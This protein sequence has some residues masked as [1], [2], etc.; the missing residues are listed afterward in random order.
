M[1]AASH[2]PLKFAGP[3]WFS[4]VMGL[5]GLSLAWYRAQPLMGDHAGVLAAVLGAAAA[6][7]FAVL[8]V[9]A[10]R[11]WQRYP[12]AW[13]DD[14]QHPVRHAFVAALPA[15]MI[16]LATVGTAVL[17]VQSAFTP[18]LNA[19]WIA[20]AA[21]QWAV[22]V[23]VL[24][25]WWRPG[26]AAGAVANPGPGA[27]GFQWASITPVMF[28]P[29]VGNVLVPLAGVPLGHADWSAA[30]F[31]VGVLF[32]PVLLVLIVVRI[33][34]Q[35]FWP[36]RLLPSAFIFLAPPAVV[37]TSLL[38]MGAPAALAWG[39]WG[40]ALFSLL[41]VGT[42]LPRIKRLEFGLPH[43]AMSFPLA[44]TA[45]LSLRLATPGSGMALFALALL[46]LASVV[47]FALLAGT[48]RGLRQGTLLAPEPVATLQVVGSA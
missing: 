47:V 31:G 24:A 10:V 44:S 11:R 8:A 1:T 22:T 48:V 6:L 16:L 25:C 4:I 26:K 33:A 19:L 15:S 12:Q 23:W 38:Q 3:A 9:A 35:G 39:C 36:E 29:V 32:W 30:Q 17:G 20:G 27:G 21:L 42:L 14:L 46:A 34:Q 18:A 37:G 5:T 43:W 45:A 7:V 40:V 13:R 2:T 28:I 41:W